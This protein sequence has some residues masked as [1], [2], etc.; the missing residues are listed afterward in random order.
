MSVAQR[1]VVFFRA[2]TELDRELHKELITR[3]GHFNG[4][5]KENGLYIQPLYKVLN[6][7][8]P[9]VITLESVQIQAKTLGA[10]K[11]LESV[12]VKAKTQG[13]GKRQSGR[14]AWHSDTS[15]E[16]NPADL[17]SLRLTK[18]SKE[19]GGEQHN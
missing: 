12:E 11:S 13:A 7:A 2:Q 5:P 1:G 3:L 10:G 15:F 19:G 14:A 17:S 4:R 9:E 18:M 16:K 8:D 6:A